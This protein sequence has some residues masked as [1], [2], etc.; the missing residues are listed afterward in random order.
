M[1][2]L[3]TTK[4]TL[5]ALV[6]LGPSLSMAEKLWSSYDVDNPSCAV[7][8][9]DPTAYWYGP[10]DLK[11]LPEKALGAPFAS[12]WHLVNDYAG[13]DYTF[14][15]AKAND[16]KASLGFRSF[17]GKNRQFKVRFYSDEDGKDLIRT[18]WMPQ[19]DT[20]CRPHT[21]D[22]TAK[23]DIP[24]NYDSVKKVTI[25]ERCTQSVKDCLK[26]KN[27]FEHP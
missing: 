27:Y 19:I 26:N 12:Y 4:A 13:S 18:Y 10:S 5:F 1:Q 16:E 6:A 24:I 7:Y 22:A 9:D 8:Y 20:Y 11:K 25:Q 23:I 21:Y 14:R 17:K 3:L 2:F 15:V